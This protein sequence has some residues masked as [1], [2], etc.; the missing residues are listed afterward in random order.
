MV[1]HYPRSASTRCAE[2]FA[3][4]FDAVDGSANISEAAAGAMSAS[5]LCPIDSSRLAAW[6]LA[7]PR[8]GL[9]NLRHGRSDDLPSGIQISTGQ[10]VCSAGNK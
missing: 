10:V 7:D 3:A 1:D 4:A 6:E 2:E 5:Q 9:P 8:L